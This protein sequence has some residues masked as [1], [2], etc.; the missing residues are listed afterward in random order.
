MLRS[1]LKSLIKSYQHIEKAGKKPQKRNIPVMDAIKKIIKCN[2]FTEKDNVEVKRAA[3]TEVV[4]HTTKRLKNCFVCNDKIPCPD[5]GVLL[6]TAISDRSDKKYFDV[7]YNVFA[8]SDHFE[9]TPGHEDVVCRNCQDQLDNLCHFIQKAKKIEDNLLQWKIGGVLNARHGNVRNKSLEK[10]PEIK[11]ETL[12][13][14]RH[15]DEDE[16]QEIVNVYEVH[17]NKKND[18]VSNNKTMQ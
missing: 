11:K 10:I 15:T 8:K 16:H 3:S 17:Y 14:H 2:R 5:N 13:H 1:K 7:L 6:S 12:E 18:S 9:L 4:V